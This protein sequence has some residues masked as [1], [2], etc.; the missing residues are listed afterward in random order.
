MMQAGQYRHAVIVQQFKVKCIRKAPQQDTPKPVT[1]RGISLR[2][3]AELLFCRSNDPQKIASPTRN[4]APRTKRM[5]RQFPLAQEAQ[6][7]P[8]KSQ[9]HTQSLGNLSQCFPCG[10][11]TVTAVGAARQL[12]KNFRA[13]FWCG[14][15]RKLIPEVFY[16]LQAL[17]SA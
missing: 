12:V 6:R 15:G 8:S 1:C 16:Q 7:R 17:E 11:V 10:R 2:I 5:L 9:M 3:A 13:C 4:F 14:L